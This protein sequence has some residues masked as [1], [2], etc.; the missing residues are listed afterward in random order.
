MKPISNSF[1]MLL[2]ISLL[3]Q[4]YKEERRFVKTGSK[5]LNKRSELCVK[6]SK[7]WT[8]N[9]NKLKPF[10]ALIS[11]HYEAVQRLPREFVIICNLTFK[12][13]I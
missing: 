10:P 8:N 12:L 7:R 5:I 4:M 11:F 3:I 6:G 13:E 1:F 9:C 2:V